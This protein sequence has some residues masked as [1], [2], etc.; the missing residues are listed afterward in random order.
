MNIHR[1]LFSSCMTSLLFVLLL[2]C[3]TSKPVPLPEEELLTLFQLKEQAQTDGR[4]VKRK[5]E[6]SPSLESRREVIVF[7]DQYSKLSGSYNGAI[8]FLR[9]IVGSGGEPSHYAPALKRDIAAM[10]QRADQLHSLREDITGTRGPMA[11]ELANAATSQLA[12]LVI[13]VIDTSKRIEEGELLRQR[14]N[15]KA[16]LAQQRMKEYGDL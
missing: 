9:T 10:R 16:Q 1:G 3:A 6:R 11:F 14:E 13:T 4:L 2:S 8:E 5:T 12:E 15:V 7:K